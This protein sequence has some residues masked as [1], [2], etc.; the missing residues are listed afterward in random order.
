MELV[1][2]VEPRNATRSRVKEVRQDGLVPGVVYGQ[3]G[4]ATSLQFKE[5][6]L[7]R[8]LR[9]G[10]SSQLMQLQGLESKPVHALMREVQRHPTRRTIMHVDFYQVQMDVAIRTD[11]PIHFEGASPAIK[12]GAIL[13]HNLDRI[14]VEC[15]PSDIPENF[16][17]DLSLLQTTD[18][19]FRIEQLAVPNGV[20][21]LHE[22]E[23][24]VVSLTIP[25]IAVEVEEEE[26]FEEGDVALVG[27]DEEGDEEDNE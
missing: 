3:G 2:N 1:L 5:I 14:S 4:E 6:D 16:V 27:E 11:I 13:L 9:V 10:A 26:E 24:V 25:R 8:L 7:V 17:I 23:D 15:L 18:D 20:T 22:P 12:G 21:I 19:V